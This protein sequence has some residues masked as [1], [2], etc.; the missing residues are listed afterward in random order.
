MSNEIPSL[1]RNQVI[2]RDRSRCVRCTAP[3]PVGHW[4]HRRSRSIKDEFT[5]SPA[6]GVWLCH[7]CHTWVHAHPF[8][9]RATGLIVSRYAD[10]ET[11]PLEHALYGRVLLNDDGTVKEIEAA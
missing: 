2:A 4:H 5:H 6:N 10:P 1:S 8:E 3:A 9:A 11:E 7:L